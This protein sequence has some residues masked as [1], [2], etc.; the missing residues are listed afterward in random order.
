[1]TKFSIKS[2]YSKGY[3]SLHIILSKNF[4]LSFYNE[5]ILLDENSYFINNV[6]LLKMSYH[7]VYA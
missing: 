1:M 7:I 6:A 5:N 2:F 3:S 4:I